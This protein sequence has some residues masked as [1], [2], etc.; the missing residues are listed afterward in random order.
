MTESAT[1]TCTGAVLFTDLVGFTEYNDA[2]GD[3]D[4]VMYLMCCGAG[5]VLS[6]ATS[7]VIFEQV[8]LINT[9]NLLI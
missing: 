2:V 7:T 3:R 4:A 5:T 9:G 1:A 8:R 6:N